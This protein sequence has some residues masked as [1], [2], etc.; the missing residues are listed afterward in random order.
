[1]GVVGVVLT[2]L[3]LPVIVSKTPGRFCE[4]PA[5]NCRLN[6]PVTPLMEADLAAGAVWAERPA[7]V[8]MSLELLL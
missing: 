6:M 8:T 7:E 5:S 2:L 4:W 1:M 3:E